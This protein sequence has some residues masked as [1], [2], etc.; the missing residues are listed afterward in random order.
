MS[1]GCFT[2]YRQLTYFFMAISSVDAFFS[3]RQVNVWTCSVLG[4]CICEMK[5]QDSRVS[6]PEIIF[7]L[8]LPLINPVRCRRGSK[9]CVEFT[10]CHCRMSLSLRKQLCHLSLMRNTPWC[11][12]LSI[13]SPMS[14]INFK[15]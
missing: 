2:P 13:F 5:S 4:D 1:D 9:C 12:S 7:A 11:M 8:L 3:L 6:K 15:K 10:K 14:P